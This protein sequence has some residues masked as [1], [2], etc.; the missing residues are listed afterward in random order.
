MPF[1]ILFYTSNQYNKNY[2][3]INKYLIFLVCYKIKN[4]K[5]YIMKTSDKPNWITIWTFIKRISLLN[6]CDRQYSQKTINVF[7]VYIYIIWG[8]SSLVKKKENA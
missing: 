4:K 1:Q 8:F 7:N 6:F 5:I 2:N 3:L